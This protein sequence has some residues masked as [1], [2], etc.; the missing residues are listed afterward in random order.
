MTV[1]AHF[2]AK[3]WKLQYL[4][5]DTKDM[6]ENHSAANIAQRLGKVADA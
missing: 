4:V 6:E 5:L 3:A 2:I 1:T